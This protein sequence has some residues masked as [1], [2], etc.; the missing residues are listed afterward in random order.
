MP[1][2]HATPAVL[3]AGPSRRESAPRRSRRETHPR[4][5]HR[6]RADMPVGDRAG[7]LVQLVVLEPHLGQDARTQRE[8]DTSAH[9]PHVADGRW[10]RL[11]VGSERPGR[12]AARAPP[13][14]RGDQLDRQRA[15]RLAD[16][17]EPRGASH[18]VTE[19][20]PTIVAQ[21]GLIFG[22]QIV[23]AVVV[24]LT[25][26]IIALGLG[27]E[28]YG[29][30][31]VLF[32][33]LGYCTALDFGLSFALVKLVA[34][35]HAE[36]DRAEIDA[37]VNAVSGVYAAVAGAFL[38]TLI[39]GR[40]W[41]VGGLL[42][43]P[44]ALAPV[45]QE[46][47]L[48]LAC[49]VPFATAGA[50]FGA[51][52]RGLLRFDLVALFSVTNAVVYA[53]GASVLVSAGASL[54]TVIGLYAVVTAVSSFVQW[55]VLRRLLPGFCPVPRV[56]GK[57]LRQLFGF[58][59]FMAFNQISRIALLQLDRLIVARM[60]SMSMVAYYAVP[61]GISQHLQSVR[62]VAWLTLAP[63]VSVI[64]FA[65][66][67]LRYWMSQEFAAH[68]TLPLRL[69][70]F[71]ILWISIAGLDQ[72]SIEGSGRPRMTSLFMGITGVM[73]VVG[74]LVL[75][76]RWGLGGAATSV[77]VSLL[78]LAGLDVWYYN[79]KVRRGSLAVW[80]RSVVLPMVWTTLLSLPVALL[81]RK[82]VTG[83]PSLGVVA[84]LATGF[85]CVIGFWFFLAAEERRWVRTRVAQL[86]G[87]LR[88]L[89][90]TQRGHR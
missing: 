26:P 30:Y 70:A 6:Q 43:V 3:W 42:R 35:R 57:Q 82:G 84:L 78:V 64:V 55:A 73:D 12:G 60:L 27:V 16:D 19:P 20:R 49:S 44:E 13:A 75:T 69:L 65:D 36:K 74:L 58:G 46:A 8:V 50:A 66:Q 10:C 53:I 71:G 61:V 56:N 9:Q 52:L 21:A 24:F 67:I 17:G 48:L 11:H 54:A 77:A 34:E 62:V 23:S 85:T 89:S 76:P 31:T 47:A 90:E 86:A 80:M 40:K 87:Q 18:A 2:A 32:L 51:V 38:L 88:V 22:A 41:I 72:V 81:L 15:C 29:V 5:H 45:T 7:H 14:E 33:L 39:A 4:A 83:L 79:K 1:A 25:T 68:G 28:R 63:V 59:S 37:L